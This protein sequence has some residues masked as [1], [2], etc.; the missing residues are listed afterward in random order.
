METGPR[1]TSLFSR[2]IYCRNV[3]SRIRLTEKKTDACR[4]LLTHRRWSLW[5]V[6]VSLLALLVLVGVSVSVDRFTDAS[7][8]KQASSRKQSWTAVAVVSDGCCDVEEELTR[9]SSGCRCFN[10]EIEDLELTWG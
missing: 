6:A 8:T 9:I 1:V 10:E 5:F 7:S 2:Q 4:L 3:S